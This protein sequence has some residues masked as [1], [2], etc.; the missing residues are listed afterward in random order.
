MYRSAGEN[1]RRKESVLSAWKM[2][3]TRKSSAG[4]L[5]HLM[6]C[7]ILAG[8]RMKRERV[9][10]GADKKCLWKPDYGETGEGT[11]TEPD[12]YHQRHGDGD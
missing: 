8:C 12:G 6:R 10:R 11:C 9:C 5:Q 7:I 2:R 4:F 1:C 3:G